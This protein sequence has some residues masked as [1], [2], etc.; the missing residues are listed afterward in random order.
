MGE[1]GCVFAGLGDGSAGPALILAAGLSPPYER[2]RASG[3]RAYPPRS[4][5]KSDT[6][7]GLPPDRGVAP[8]THAFAPFWCNSAP[9][10]AG[11]APFTVSDAAFFAIDAPRRGSVGPFRAIDAAFFATHAPFRGCVGPRSGRH[12]PFWCN[13]GAES[14]N[15]GAFTGMRAPFWCIVGPESAGD[16]ARTGID[17]AFFA[18]DGPSRGNASPG[19][20]AGRGRDWEGACVGCSRVQPSALPGRR[21]L[22]PA[23]RDLPIH[24]AG[25]GER[26]RHAV[27]P[28]TSETS[29]PG[30]WPSI[31]G[32][33]PCLPTR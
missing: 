3:R 21:G 7:G 14:G 19:Q 33:R 12:A 5:K 4:H 30:A 31:R 20:G 8:R 18:S 1:G 2:L 28:G 26:C 29:R 9:R 6:P 23:R 13:V 25:S 32:G 10:T 22:E 24:L 11:V 16:G 17:G 15:V 27:I